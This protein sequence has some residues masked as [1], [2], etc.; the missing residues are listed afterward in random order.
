MIE[1]RI[2]LNRLTEAQLNQ[3][4]YILESIKDVRQAELVEKYLN[5]QV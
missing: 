1:V 5:G 4:Y 3:L 2:E